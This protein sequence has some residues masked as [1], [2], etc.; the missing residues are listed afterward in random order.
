MQ[1]SNQITERT[2][3]ISRF[4]TLRTRWIKIQSIGQTKSRP[5]FLCFGFAIGTIKVMILFYSPILF[6][7]CKAITVDAHNKPILFKVCK[8]FLLIRQDIWKLWCFTSSRY[9]KLLTVIYWTWS[10][11]DQTFVE[12]TLLNE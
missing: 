2:E 11:T 9:V 4:Q 1:W 12:Y 6:A 3:I 10:R 5:K 8:S 7:S